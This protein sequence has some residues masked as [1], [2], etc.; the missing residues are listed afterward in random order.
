[1][2]FEAYVNN[3]LITKNYEDE[4]LKAMT[5]DEKKHM[6]QV[7]L[8]YYEEVM[9]LQLDEVKTPEEFCKEEWPEVLKSQTDPSPTQSSS[10][11]DFSLVTS[12]FL[13]SPWCKNFFKKK[14]KN[15]KDLNINMIKV[16]EDSKLTIKDIE[17]T[18]EDSE[19]T[20]KDNKIT[21]ED[22]ETIETDP[23]KKMNFITSKLQL[24]KNLMNNYLI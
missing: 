13:V 15:K 4:T 17:I 24:L 1:M 2:E 8:A 10:D 22:S 9:G 23:K 3:T 6:V 7:V 20:I 21:D 11:R 18:D 12:K 14:Y 5:E 16:P 19:L